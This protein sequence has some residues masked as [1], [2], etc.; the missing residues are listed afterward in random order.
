MK[1]ITLT[2]TDDVILPPPEG[3]ILLTKNGVVVMTIDTLMAATDNV[4]QITGLRNVLSG[5]KRRKK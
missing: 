1:D 2:Q 4:V 3:N 5:R